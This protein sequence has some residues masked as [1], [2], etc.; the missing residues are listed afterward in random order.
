MTIISIL[1]HTSWKVHNIVCIIQF[2]GCSGHLEASQL[3]YDANSLTSFFARRISI[4]EQ[5]WEIS[6]IM[7]LTVGYLYFYLFY[8]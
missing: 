6:K 1:R 8:V 5:F 3:I 7:F 2:S 4:E